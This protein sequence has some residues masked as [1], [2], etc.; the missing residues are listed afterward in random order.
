MHQQAAS[1][2]V[3]QAVLGGAVDESGRK[4]Q[5][6]GCRARAFGAG[7]QLLA[8]VTGQHGQ[9]I[10]LLRHAEMMVLF[11]SGDDMPKMVPKRVYA[12][13]SMAH[14]HIP[15]RTPTFS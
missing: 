10:M 4:V 2:G 1:K 3:I 11:V 8:Y 14:E 5:H 6:G 7:L 9:P 12:K 15:G 13:F